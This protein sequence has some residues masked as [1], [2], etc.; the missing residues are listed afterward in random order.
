MSQI[1]R[2]E[3]VCGDTKADEEGQLYKM[4]EKT[5]NTSKGEAFWELGQPAQGSSACFRKFILRHYIIVLSIAALALFSVSR[6]VI[7]PCPMPVIP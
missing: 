4:M 7:Q 1:I 2:E 5:D 6:K 3:M